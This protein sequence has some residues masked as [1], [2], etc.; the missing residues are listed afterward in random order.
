MSVLVKVFA[1]IGALLLSLPPLLLVI[2]FWQLIPLP[3]IL[4]AL[5]MVAGGFLWWVLRK[6]SKGVAFSEAALMGRQ[7]SKDGLL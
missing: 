3:S 6:R 7:S 4:I 2:T 5:A 1:V